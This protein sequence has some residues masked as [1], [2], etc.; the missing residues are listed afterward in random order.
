[1]C[2]FFVRTAIMRELLRCAIGFV[3][4]CGL[5]ACAAQQRP[6]AASAPTAVAGAAPGV[7]VTAPPVKPET[8][9]GTWVEFWARSGRA[10]TQH[11]AFFADGRFGWRAAPDSD[12]RVMRSW[13]RYRVEGGT[14]V[15]GIE[16]HEERY[17]CEGFAVCRVLHE[18][19]Q[20]ERLALGQCPPND[21]ARTIDPSYTCVSIGGRAFW[22]N[23]HAPQDESSFFPPQA[24]AAAPTQAPSQN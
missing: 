22:R 12:E 24:A 5:V 3:V 16:G 18:P 15:L 21:E 7:V 10:D 20:E 19:P 13:G 14:I 6:V 9:A 1:L 23:T 11:Y 4:L 17:G 2:A 8:L